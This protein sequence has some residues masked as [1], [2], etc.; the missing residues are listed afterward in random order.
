MTLLR[1]L[2]NQDSRV[3][4]RNKT[5]CFNNIKMFFGEFVTYF[6]RLEN[7]EKIQLTN[8]ATTL[9]LDSKLATKS[10]GKSKG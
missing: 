1:Y 9:L 3:A 4:W 6:K 2:S 7:L 5:L 8:I 10:I